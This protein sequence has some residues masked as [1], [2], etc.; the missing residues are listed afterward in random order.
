MALY[1]PFYL[2]PDVQTDVTGGGLGA[3]EGG[4]YMLNLCNDLNAEVEV[5]A[6]YVTDGEAPTFKHKVQP[7]QTIEAYGW[8]SILPLKLG[9]G[10]KVFLAANRP[11][12]VQ[13]NAQAD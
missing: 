1:K 9:P 3:S 8:R 4:T 11:L 2:E 5:T 10:F 12:S 13:L 6:V 7:S